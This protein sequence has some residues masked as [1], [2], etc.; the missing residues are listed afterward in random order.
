MTTALATRTLGELEAEIDENLPTFL[1]VGR[2]L[3]EIQQR[4]L[5]KPQYASFA[6]YCAKRFNIQHSR[7]YQLMDA[8]K[9]AKGMSTSVDKETHLRELKRLPAEQ[10]DEAY[11]EAGDQPTQRAVREVVDRRLPDWKPKSAN[12]RPQQQPV[13]WDGKE[14]WERD[15]DRGPVPDTTTTELTDAI[16]TL[17]SSNLNSIAFMDSLPPS[18]RS[19]VRDQVENAIKW[20][21]A[22]L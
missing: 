18:I 16:A 19:S 11:A 14:D 17:A 10:R 7:A 5:Y 22:A 13:E 15:A 3:L 4:Q 1:V 12:R 20:L 6:E 21:T 8:A 2:A 9:T